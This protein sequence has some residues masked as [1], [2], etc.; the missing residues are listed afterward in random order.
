MCY[1]YI[2]SW[3]TVALHVCPVLQTMLTCASLF[4][5]SADYACYAAGHACNYTW[6]LANAFHTVVGG[7]VT[8]VVEP[9]FATSSSGPM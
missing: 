1:I 8:L 9:F 4:N 6:S 5:M 3:D 7:R 2:H